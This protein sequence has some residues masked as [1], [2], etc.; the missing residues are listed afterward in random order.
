MPLQISYSLLIA[1]HL[2]TAAGL[3]IGGSASAYHLAR[4][5]GSWRIQGG[6]PS[7]PWTNANFLANIVV[8]FL[9]IFEFA[10]ALVEILLC[11]PSLTRVQTLRNGFLRPLVYLPLGVLT[12]GVA[13][14]LG[15]AAAALILA[16]AALWLVLALMAAL[17]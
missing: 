16:A 2:F 3:I 17:Q 4:L 8:L 12:L 11:I 10:F 1:F 15:I 7:K 14:S 9:A 13:A 5:E 6:D